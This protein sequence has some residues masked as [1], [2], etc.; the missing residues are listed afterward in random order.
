M[1]SNEINQ[2]YRMDDWVKEVNLSADSPDG[3]VHPQT[4]AFCEDIFILLSH[5]S[6][7]VSKLH[8]QS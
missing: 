5:V 8:Y 6:V 3:L 2:M 4:V 7:N 1:E